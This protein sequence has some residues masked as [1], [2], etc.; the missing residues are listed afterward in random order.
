VEAISTKFLIYSHLPNH[1]EDTEYRAVSHMFYGAL[2][3]YLS[4]DWC[5]MNAPEEPT[6]DDGYWVHTLQIDSKF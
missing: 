5:R 1:L 4:L 3:E 6:I 2:M